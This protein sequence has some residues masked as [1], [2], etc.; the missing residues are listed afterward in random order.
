MTIDNNPTI[1]VDEVERALPLAKSLIRSK[2]L[3][4]Q[5]RRRSAS[6]E[7]TSPRR[8]LFSRK[9]NLHA[10]AYDYQKRPMHPIAECIHAAE[11]IVVSYRNGQQAFP[12][13]VLCSR[14]LSLRDVALAKDRVEGVSS[15]LSKL[16]GPEWKSTLY[17]LLTAVSYINGRH[18]T[19]LPDNSEDPIPDLEIGSSEGLF[20]ECKARLR[21]EQEV[22]SFTKSW[23]QT[24]L[25][26]IFNAFVGR[27]RSAIV[28]IDVDSIKELNKA[29]SGAIGKMVCGML[30]K[31]QSTRHRYGCTVDIENYPALHTSLSSA[32]SPMG[33]AIWEHGWNFREWAEW[34]HVF[35]S[36][37][38]AISDADGRVATAYGQR[39][40]VCVRAKE[41]L[42]TV[43]KVR[44]VIKSA[45]RKQL[46]KAKTGILHIHLNSSLYGLGEQRHPKNIANSL[47]DEIA[48]V[49]GEYS[50]LWRVYID[51]THSGEMFESEAPS[52]VRINATNKNGSSPMHFTEPREVLLV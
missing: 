35:P 33:A 46:R 25:V 30:A 51:V 1:G 43:P 22:V 14:L 24:Q 9:Q 28:R 13:A 19:L 7:L 16:Q 3:E 27:Q 17:E 34:H 40:L 48:R 20:V 4:K 45:A 18:V 47:K 23:R 21:F 41:L 6:Q 44:Q 49:F 36:G 39:L 26:G 31:P 50:R 11:Q 29:Q 2:W 5:K 42:S 38:I 52:C 12:S 8:A 37:D 15:R 32:Y 10:V